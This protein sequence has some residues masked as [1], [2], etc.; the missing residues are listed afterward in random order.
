MPRWGRMTSIF[1]GSVSCVLVST[2][3][4][5][6]T[7]HFLSKVFPIEIR[8]GRIVRERRVRDCTGRLVQIGALK[9]KP[10]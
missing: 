7:G 2:P 8:N 10:A 1:A 6:H 4:D 3:V 9:A 5:S